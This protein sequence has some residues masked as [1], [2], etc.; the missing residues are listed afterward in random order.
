MLSEMSASEYSGWV[1]HFASTPFSNELLDAEFATT[2]G[3]LV[4]M[5][6]GKADISDEEFS[7]LSGEE[8]VGR[9]DDDLMLA[10]EGLFGGVRY[11]PAD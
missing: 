2:K 3:L 7:L 1:K 6:T 10:G 11:G 9:T 5:L 8:D 4:A